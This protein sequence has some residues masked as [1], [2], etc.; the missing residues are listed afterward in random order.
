M[1]AVVVVILQASIAGATVGEEIHG[2]IRQVEDGGSRAIQTEHRAF[3]EG[4]FTSYAFCRRPVQQGSRDIRDAVDE[5][6]E[7]WYPEP[8]HRG[9]ISIICGHIPQVHKGY[10]SSGNIKIIN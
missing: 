5:H 4:I 2:S 6:G 8:I 10:K 1:Q 9:R 7:W 3:R